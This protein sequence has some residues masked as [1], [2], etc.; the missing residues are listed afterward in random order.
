M[1]KKR[2]PVWREGSSVSSTLTTML[3]VLGLG[4]TLLCTMGGVA[5]YL[6]RDAVERASRD[7]DRIERA[8]SDLQSEVR[9]KITRSPTGECLDPG[10][11]PPVSAIPNGG[12][13]SPW[14]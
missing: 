2:S 9:D 5:V 12:L 7:V 4:L 14:F 3:G 11:S 1:G 10:A 6:H 13:P 8:L